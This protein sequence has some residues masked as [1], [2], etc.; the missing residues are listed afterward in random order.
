MLADILA[1]LFQAAMTILVI[2]LY[3]DFVVRK[4]FLKS[5]TNKTS[6][7]LWQETSSAS[8]EKLELRLEQMQNREMTARERVW[9][10]EDENRVLNS[11]VQQLRSVGASYKDFVPTV[12]ADN[13][14]LTEDIDDED[15]E[16]RK[17]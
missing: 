13:N 11:H 6:S 14:I 1:V 5:D 4:H 3:H 10:L 16:P 17:V 2:K 7:N 9:M 15:D 8:M 12:D